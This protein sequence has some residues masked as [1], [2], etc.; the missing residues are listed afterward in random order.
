MMH[1][2]NSRLE[3][4]RV[5]RSLMKGSITDRTPNRNVSN[6]P[7]TSMRLQLTYHHRL[8]TVARPTRLSPMLPTEARRRLAIPPPLTCLRPR[9][10]VLHQI[11][12]PSRAGRMQPA[13]PTPSLLGTATQYQ[14][15]ASRADSKLAKKSTTT[16]LKSNAKSQPQPHQ[17]KRLVSAKSRPT[18]KQFRR[19]TRLRRA[20]L[21]SR[22]ARSRRRLRTLLSRVCQDSLTAP[23]PLPPWSL[24]PRIRCLLVLTRL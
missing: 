8:P 3:V 16:L 7:Q 22:R 6:L 21:L 13:G 4:G 11:P 14:R 10:L 12:P 17:Q 15:L 1:H 9:A 2:V 24:L 19:R 20:R 5:R 18:R 23:R